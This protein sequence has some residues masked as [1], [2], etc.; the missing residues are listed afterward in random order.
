MDRGRLSAFK[1]E[2]LLFGQ[3]SELLYQNKIKIIRRYQRSGKVI[4]E[5]TDDAKILFETNVT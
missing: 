2:E 3:S 1:S 5:M 4:K